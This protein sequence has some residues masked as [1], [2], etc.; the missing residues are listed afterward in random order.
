V[1]RAVTK[2]RLVEVSANLSQGAFKDFF[3]AINSLN[4]MDYATFQ[5]GALEFSRYCYEQFESESSPKAV[6]RRLVAMLSSW[7]GVD[8]V[9]LVD[10]GS[11]DSS[12]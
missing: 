2:E 6:M 1:E 5:G 10:I 7:I 3:S 4:S 11:A 8:R 12:D 9:S